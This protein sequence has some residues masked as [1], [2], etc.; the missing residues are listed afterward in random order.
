MNE[1]MMILATS[2]ILLTGRRRTGDTAEAVGRRE[3]V[4]SATTPGASTTG[5]QQPAKRDRTHYLYIAVIGAVFLGIIVGLVAPGVGK[6]LQPLGTGFVNLIKMMISPV[7]F[8]TIV[9]GIGSIR[10]AAKV[11]KVGGLALLYFIVMSTVALIIGLVVGNILHPGEGLVIPAAGKT[12]AQAAAA[13]P[14]SSTTDF[15][16]H[17]IPTTLFSHLVGDSVLST[18][19]VALLVG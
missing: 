11:G 17:I 9:L 7:I 16:L 18:L 14:A 19:F 6:A 13:A 8:C 15:L 12:A 4:V 10:Q 2:R 5:A 1:I 3:D